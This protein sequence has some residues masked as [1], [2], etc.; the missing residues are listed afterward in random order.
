MKT[1]ILYAMLALLGG[2]L[3]IQAT[4][5]GKVNRSESNWEG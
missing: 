3:L 5:D 2:L 1:K 4:L